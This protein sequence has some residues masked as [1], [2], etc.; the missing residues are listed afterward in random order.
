MTSL[1]L[2]DVVVPLSRRIKIRQMPAEVLRSTKLVVADTLGVAWAGARD[3]DCQGA[4][5]LALG[6][7]GAEV[8]RIW[9]TDHRVP[10]RSAAFVNGVFSAGLDFDALHLGSVTHPAIVVI[11]TVLSLAEQRGIGGERVVEAITAGMEFICWLA[12]SAKPT[13]AYFETSFFGVFGAALAGALVIGLDDDAVRNA[14]GLGLSL[15]SGTKQAISE[16]KLAKRYQSAFAAQMGVTCALL[17]EQGVT[18]PR[19]FLSGSAG[20]GALVGGIDHEMFQN[21][22]GTKYLTSELSI[23]PFPICYCS[24]AAVHAVINLK[25]K[26]AIPVD[27]IVSIVVVVTPYIFETVGSPFDPS[28]DPQV[29]GMFSIQYAIACG[30]LFGEVR[31]DHVQPS[32]VLSE[33]I[34]ELARR[35]EVRT[36]EDWC[37]EFAPTGVTVRMRD[38]TVMSH[39]VELAPV[40]PAS[41]AYDVIFKKVRECLGRNDGEEIPLSLNAFEDVVWR[42]E[43]LE[44]VT[45][46]YESLPVPLSARRGFHEKR[47]F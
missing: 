16:R 1:S 4:L 26:R 23:K 11:P 9:G 24:I 30:L 37:G 13:G 32:T 27:Q 44:N 41:D 15:A 12:I 5:A 6:E 33:H 38:G 20:V 29:A 35:I 25:A 34:G 36:N 28:R 46:L 22:F 31:L 21:G 2:D 40:I 18:A 39:V 43:E 17:A 8:S 14:L 45:T 7:G 19:D 42:L 47:S 10:P 3:G